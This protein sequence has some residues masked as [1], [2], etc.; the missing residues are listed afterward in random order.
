MSTYLPC[1]KCGG[2]I[3]IKV[4]NYTWWGGIFGNKLFNHVICDRCKFEYNGV[5]GKSNKVNII[6]YNI[7]VSIIVLGMIALL[8][9]LFL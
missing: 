2:K 1:P 6:I 3:I 4:E 7:I 8:Y 9:R 5:T